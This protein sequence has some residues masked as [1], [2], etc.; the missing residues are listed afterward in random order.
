MS[1]KDLV[2]VARAV[3]GNWEQFAACLDP[4]LFTVLEKKIIR[5]SHSEPFNQ[6]HAMLEKWSDE[7]DKKATNVSL[8][9]V[10]LENNMKAQANKI[11]GECLVN[12]VESNRSD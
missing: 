3:S 10:L 8:I 4:D 12:Y 9:E 2:K 1:N 7:L 6:S 5:Q 11:F